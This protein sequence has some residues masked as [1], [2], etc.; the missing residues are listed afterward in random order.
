MDIRN[1]SIVRQT[2]ANTVFTH[3]VQ[4]IAAGYQERCAFWVKIAN[5]VLVSIVLV[6]LFLQA[7][8][9]DQIM[10]SYIGA[11]VTIAEVIYLII[12]LSFSS[13]QRMIM[14]KSSALKYL[15]LRDCY[16][17]LITDIMNENLSNETIIARRD[18]LQHEYQVI[19][20]LAPQ[21][22]Q[23]EY[24]EAQKKLNNRGIVRGEEF[25]WSDKEIDRFL[26]ELLRL[27]D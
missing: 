14:H 15:G 7:S 23:K 25:T 12:Q 3:T 26:P 4:E 20:D 24:N 11:G 5:I 16:R 10:F 9:P 13:E 21:T 27:N 6:L 19:C 1:L 17:S 8:H 22:G 2:F 18:S